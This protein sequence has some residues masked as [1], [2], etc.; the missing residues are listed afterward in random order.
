MFGTI[1][2][3]GP[4]HNWLQLKLKDAEEEEVMEG[5]LL[6]AF[7]RNNQTHTNKDAKK[8]E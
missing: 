7:G 2:A 8:K 3:N 6:Q 1:T 4:E 5:A